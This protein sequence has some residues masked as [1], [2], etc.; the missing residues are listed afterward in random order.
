MAGSA[1]EL[2]AVIG[3]NTGKL[4]GAVK[5]LKVATTASGVGNLPSSAGALAGSVGMDVIFKGKS[6]GYI[7]KHDNKDV[8]LLIKARD[9]EEDPLGIYRIV[10]FQTEKDRRRIQ[11]CEYEPAFLSSEEAKK[12]GFL[13]FTGHKYGEQ[14]YLLTIPA[15]EIE[16]GVYGIFFMQIIMGTSIPVGTFSV[17]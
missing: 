4:S 2:G 8:R 1:G 3:A 16:K 12:S 6:S 17:R 13:Y 9:N 5:G 14:S 15:A 11:W 10:K 7:Y